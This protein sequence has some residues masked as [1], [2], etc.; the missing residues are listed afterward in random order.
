[1]SIGTANLVRV[2]DRRSV[3]ASHAQP[4]PIA[5]VGSGEFL[6]AMAATDAALLAGRQARVAVVP[7]AAGLESAERIRY[8]FDLAHAHY[9]AM[10]VEVVEVHAFDR[11]AADNP[12]QAA[13]F[14]GVGL[15]YL[16]GGDPHHVTT[17]LA[18]TAVWR[19][20]ETAWRA[21]AAL[22]G[23]SAGAMTLAGKVASIRGR[24]T[25][26]GLGLVPG[27]CVLPHFDRLRVNYPDLAARVSVELGATV[28]GIDEDTALV[29]TGA[30]GWRVEGK[31]SVH[32][33]G[34][35]SGAVIHPSGSE[36]V[37]W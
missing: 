21:G 27:V 37:G 34:G 19:A 24:A 8:W 3:N 7:T 23:C 36:G 20:I 29:S 2:A 25:I 13:L 5:L 10:G 11:A 15:V 16:S 35:E 17:T 6:P 31:A 33:L 22:A 1:M 4:G 9:E 18:G 12:A 14:D 28:L 30:G 32:V 26:D